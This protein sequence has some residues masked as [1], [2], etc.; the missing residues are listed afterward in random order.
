MNIFDHHHANRRRLRWRPQP[1]NILRFRGHRRR[2]VA[3][4]TMRCHLA[5]PSFIAYS[6]T[7]SAHVLRIN[8]HSRR[9]RRRD[10]RL[11]DGWLEITPVMTISA[12]ARSAVCGGKCMRDRALGD[13]RIVQ[14]RVCV[15]VSE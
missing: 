10:G 1:P 2:R 9:R 8:T 11:F 7:Y 6:F 13:A 3:E 14:S 15:C 12:R 5:Q 4:P